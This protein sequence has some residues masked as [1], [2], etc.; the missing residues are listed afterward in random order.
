MNAK[1]WDVNFKS[2]MT[3]ELGYKGN[4]LGSIPATGELYAVDL[5]F[6]PHSEPSPACLMPEFAAFIQA[7]LTL[8]LWHAHLGHLGQNTI[9]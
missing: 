6:I 5:D 4:T 2:N 7:P 1:G 8:D 9:A 3:C